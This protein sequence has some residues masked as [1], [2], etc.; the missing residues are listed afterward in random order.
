MSCHRFY[1]VSPDILWQSSSTD[2]RGLRLRAA[3][4]SNSANVSPGTQRAWNHFQSGEALPSVVRLYEA[5]NDIDAL[6]PLLLSGRKHRV[7]LTHTG[8]RAE[9]NLQLPFPAPLCFTPQM[10]NK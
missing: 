10:I 5:G 6:C 8:C 1:V 9:K 4:I 3:S 2:E 7:S